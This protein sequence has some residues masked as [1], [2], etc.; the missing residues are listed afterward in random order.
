MRTLP[1]APLALMLALAPALAALSAPVASAASGNLLVNP[2]F[3]SGLSGWYQINACPLTAASASWS[4]SGS[5]SAYMSDSSSAVPC[6]LNQNVLA[7]VGHQYTLSARFNVLSG[8]MWLYLDFW[9]AADTRTG[10]E[11]KATSGTGEQTITLSLEAPANTV[12]VV[13]WYYTD[14]PGFGEGYADDFVLVD[15]DQDPGNTGPTATEHVRVENVSV[16]GGEPLPPVGVPGATTPDVPGTPPITVTTPP[17]GPYTVPRVTAD[18][19]VLAVENNAAGTHLCVD[20]VS[21]TEGVPDVNVVCVPRSSLGAADGQIPRESVPLYAS[22]SPTQVGAD[23]ETVT[24]WPGSGPVP[25]QDVAPCPAG[26]LGTTPDV[27]VTVIAGYTY[28]TS[29][30]E[31]IA[32]LGQPV[33]YPPFPTTA[34]Q[35]EWFATHGDDV[36]LTVNVIVYR[37]GVEVAAQQIVVPWLGQLAATGGP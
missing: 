34:E 24:V 18:V 23:P 22:K 29:R 21:H 5:F 37:D 33:A 7:V 27:G 14:I 20:F 12:H 35:A 1:T 32:V 36:P 16:Q 19:G 11:Y 9:D 6:S 4:S 17:V 2:G 15:E 13:V 10:V 31:A 30:H 8:A 28:D 26:C 25:V 3:E